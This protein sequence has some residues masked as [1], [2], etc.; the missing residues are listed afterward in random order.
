MIRGI[1]D[2]HKSRR[3]AEDVHKQAPVRTSDHEA[4]LNCKLQTRL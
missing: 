4:R 2:G 1:I 3:L